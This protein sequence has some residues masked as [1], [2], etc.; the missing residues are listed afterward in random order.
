MLHDRKECKNLYV[1]QDDVQWA[2]KATINYKIRVILRE[3]AF[4]SDC[5]MVKKFIFILFYCVLFQVN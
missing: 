2:I 1:I 5:V 3:F 4:T